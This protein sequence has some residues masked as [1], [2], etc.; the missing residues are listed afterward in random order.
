[1]NSYTFFEDIAV[2]ESKNEKNNILC[3]YITIHGEIIA[4]AQFD[5]AWPFYKGFAR[6]K[7][8]NYWSVIN[9]QG[10]ICLPFDSKYE[11]IEI[12][13]GLF[14]VTKADRFGFVD[15]T[16]TVIVPLEYDWCFNFF[17]HVAIVKKNNLYGV[18]H[19]T[20]TLVA[21][22]VYSCIKPF[23]QGKAIACKDSVWGVLHI[24]GS[25]SV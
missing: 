15:T 23:A 5:V 4:D 7:K 3:G 11:R 20:G 25:F 16:N 6:V 22:C 21:D 1:M 2:F 9:T 24:D 10:D 17:E 12:C 8:G 13:D 18:V 19:D 14:K